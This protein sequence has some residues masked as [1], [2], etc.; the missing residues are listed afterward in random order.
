M[1][2]GARVGCNRWWWIT[3]SATFPWFTCARSKTTSPRSTWQHSGSTR[4]STSSKLGWQANQ[5]FWESDKYKIYG[6]ISY[7]DDPITQMWYPSYDYFSP[8]GTLTGIYTY[9]TTAQMFGRMT[10][11]E[12]VVAARKGAVKLHDE[13]N[14]EFIVPSDKAISIFWADVPFQ[15]GGGAAWNESVP[16]DQQ[17]YKRLLSPEKRFYLTGDQVSPLPGW[18]EGAMMSAE[19]VMG[20]ISGQTPA[21]LETMYHMPS[22]STIITSV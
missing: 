20:Q 5:R 1:G 21:S 22:A 3:A 9:N 7:T 2:I 8:K 11:A 6:G 18:Q 15:N 19:H 14:S 17:A 13:F 12:R 10:H 4:T 16:A